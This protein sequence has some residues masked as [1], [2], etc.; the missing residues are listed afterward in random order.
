MTSLPISLSSLSKREANTDA[1]YRCIVGLDSAD[2]ALF[3]SA[4]SEDASLDLNG[5]VMVGMDSIHSGCYEVISK[6]DTMHFIT[7][8]RV[9]TKD[10]E[11]NASMTASSLAKNY[12]LTQGMQPDAATL[13]TGAFC[14][15]DLV[16]DN[17]NSLWRF[18]RYKIKMIWSEGYW[19]VLTGK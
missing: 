9:E 8:V 17:K 12:H 4:F 7:N 18:T 6:L 19:G 3:D 15:G 1:L 11:S 16:Y 10:G 5:N 2:I 14:S 13:M